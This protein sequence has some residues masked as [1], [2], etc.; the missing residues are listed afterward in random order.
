MTWV[1]KTEKA[2]STAFVFPLGHIGILPLSSSCPF[3]PPG[4]SKGL[5]RWILNFH[6]APYYPAIVPPLFFSRVVLLQYRF[7]APILSN[8]QRWICFFESPPRTGAG[9]FGVPKHQS[10][11]KGFFGTGIQERC[12]IF[13]FLPRETDLRFGGGVPTRTVIQADQR[14]LCFLISRKT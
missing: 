2:D 12:T 11:G 10:L 9:K 6:R 5:F 3:F 13:V 4:V 8:E 1:G 7:P 14:F